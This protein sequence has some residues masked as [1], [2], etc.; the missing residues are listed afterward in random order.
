MRAAGLGLDLVRGA[1]GA[2]LA[3]LGGALGVGRRVLGLADGGLGLVH[4]VAGLR[5]VA[6]VGDEL[7][8]AD[9]EVRVQRAGLVR[10]LVELLTDGGTA[11]LGL[12]GGLGLSL[13]H[14]GLDL[15]D[16]LGT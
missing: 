7:L 3:A 2:L 5:V 9:D 10:Q 8:A 6:E 16:A 4:R 15:L 1:R 13:L 14:G 12:L 11:G